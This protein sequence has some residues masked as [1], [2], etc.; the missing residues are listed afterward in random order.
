M[1]RVLLTLLH[2]WILT[3]ALLGNGS[4]LGVSGGGNSGQYTRDVPS[5]QP[6]PDGSEKWTI[7]INVSAGEITD[8]E[9]LEDLDL[10]QVCDDDSDDGFVII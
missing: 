8:K 3:N 1:L 7:T 6:S 5:M 2:R 4:S 9:A 10:V